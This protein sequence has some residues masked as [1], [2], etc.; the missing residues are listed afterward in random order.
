MQRSPERKVVQTPA[1]RRI[2]E[3]D[4]EDE[5]GEEGVDTE[6]MSVQERRRVMAGSRGELTSSVV[7]ES[8]ALGLLELGSGRRLSG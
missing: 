6:E 1:A 2:R 5:E 3:A 4:Y 8:V 7:K